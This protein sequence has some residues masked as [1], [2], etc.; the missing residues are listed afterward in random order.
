MVSF[1][2]FK[3][4]GKNRLNGAWNYTRSR[5][6]RD[7]D[8]KHME[9]WLELHKPSIETISNSDELILEMQNAIDKKY[10]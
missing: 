6:R 1:D 7:E 3:F 2:K 8:R 4:N 9:E 5:F 10:Y